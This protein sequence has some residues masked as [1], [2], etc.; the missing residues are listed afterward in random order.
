MIRLR[1]LTLTPDEPFENLY[2]KA[3]TLLKTDIRELQIV[4]RSI[5]AR[6]KQDVHFVYTID[7]SVADERGALARYRDATP[8]P[9]YRYDLPTPVHMPDERPVVVG[10]GPAGMFAALS[11]ALAG[12]RPIVL[13]RGESAE[14]RTET[15]AHMR[16]DGVLNPESNI[17]FGEGGAGAFSDGKLTTGVKNPRIPWILDQLI[18]AGAP[19]EIAYD[20]KPHI[21]TDRLP[22]ICAN[23]RRRIESLGG[24]VRFSQKLS[25]L[26]TDS[27]QI[28]AAITEQARIPCSHLILACGH[29]ARDTFEMLC[30][31]SVPMAPKAFA[32]GV[33]IE[34]LQAETNRVQY[35]P[36]AGHPNLPPADYSLACE[37]PNGRRCYTF[38]M[39]PGGEVVP[40]ASEH[41]RVCVNG[42]SPYKR[43]YVNSNAALL[44]AVSPTDF[45][46]SGILG[47]M[48]WQRRIEEAAYEAAGGG[49]R[50][51]IETVGS[52]LS[53]H[54]PSRQRVVPSYEPG[55]TATTLRSFLPPVIA[56]TI[57]NTL[58][59]F[60]RKLK[61][62]DT[63]DAILTGPECRS[64][65][66]VRMERDEH[67]QSPTLRGL[68]PCGE[69]AG[70]A[71][72]IM[73]AAIDGMKCAEALIQEL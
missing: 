51:P 50:A 67:L 65:S 20:A 29:S 64:S 34:H 15:V 16:R 22:G 60:G 42:A 68:Y 21:G 24:E 35:G 52:F 48:E 37:L 43:D 3:G 59:V 39:C 2:K 18:K 12:L 66:P 6:K 41:G 63:P 54:S 61:G 71:G 25:A 31:L 4:R 69:G 45:P 57:Q 7:V 58:P 28:S 53:G 23:I 56:D 9:T 13:E 49:Y 11:L 14:K 33:R 47:G 36:F 46:Y 38:C 27:G 72:G 73:S 10:F 70:W 44:A 62:F 19:A 32:M 17:Q 8:T 5:D 40:A 30:K 55:V 26:E 1:N